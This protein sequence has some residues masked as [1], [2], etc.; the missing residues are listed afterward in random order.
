M[1]MNLVAMYDQAAAAEQA[2]SELLASGFHASD[3]DLIRSEREL[4]TRPGGVEG[5][6][7]SLFDEDT[8]RDYIEC[9]SE[10]LRRGASVLSVRD[11]DDDASQQVKDILNRHNPLDLDACHRDWN[12]GSHQAAGAS[13]AGAAGTGAAGMTGAGADTSETKQRIPVVEEELQVG[14]R[15]VEGDSARVVSRVRSEPVEE[16]VRLREETPTIERK[17]VDR[18]ATEADLQ[19]AQDKSI[20]VRETREEPVVSKSARVKEEVTVGQKTRER[21][22]K[23][24]DDVK[25]TEVDIEKTGKGESGRDPNRSRH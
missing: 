7:R 25:R 8:Q 13:M 2:R 19:A 18:P 9:F 12:L 20:E 3:I 24:R 6:F 1:T 10:G 4:G 15:E 22:E 17:R 21:V 14:K 23:V 11:A 5:Y 16:T